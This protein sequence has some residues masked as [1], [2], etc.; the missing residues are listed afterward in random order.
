ME[1]KKYI[2]WLFF[3]I[4][5][6][7]AF[8]EAFTESTGFFWMDSKTRFTE[9]TLSFMKTMEKDDEPYSYYFYGGG[10]MPMTTYKDVRVRDEERDTYST[11]DIENFLFS[12]DLMGIFRGENF[13]FAA[14]FL[15]G[16][17]MEENPLDYILNVGVIWTNSSYGSLGGYIGLETKKDSVGS[18][19]FDEFNFA[20][21]IVPSLALREYKYIG[22]ILDQLSGFINIVGSSVDGY[23]GSLT[24]Q[25]LKI[26]DLSIFPIE[27]YYKKEPYNNEAYNEAH[28]GRLGF[29][30]FIFIEGGYQKFLNITGPTEYYK[31]SPFGKLTFIWLSEDYESRKP[32]DSFFDSFSISGYWSD[33]YSPFPKLSFDL[34]VLGCFNYKMDIY[35]S[36]NFTEFVFGLMVNLSGVLFYM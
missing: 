6:Q 33:R 4:F 15:S 25:R 30:D 28:G 7:S 31:D 3:F 10:G 20:Y 1:N 32:F 8:S 21:W 11:E 24:T 19:F 18:G 34:G 29:N 5:T 9:K 22:L 12:A 13:A 36:S 26:G 17:R 2:V 23:S 35:Y 14:N 16:I 27:Y